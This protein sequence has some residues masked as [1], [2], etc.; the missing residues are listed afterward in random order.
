[1]KQILR[2]KNTSARAFARTGLTPQESEQLMALALAEPIQKTLSIHMTSDS[3][4]GTSSPS[5][6]ISSASRTSPSSSED[7]S[8][9]LGSDWRGSRSSFTASTSSADSL[10]DTSSDAG[11]DAMPE[12]RDIGYPDS[13]EDSS[14]SETSSASDSGEEANDEEE[15]EWD[16]AEDDGMGLDS[17]PRCSNTVRWVQHMPEDMYSQCY[18]A[19]RTPSPAGL[20]SFPMFWES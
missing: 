12:L 20:P 5:S 8:D 14:D 6:G 11:D 18:E 10:F 16:D 13:D 4:T 2:R 1:M 17:M 9:L 3:D 19:P 15:W 7:W